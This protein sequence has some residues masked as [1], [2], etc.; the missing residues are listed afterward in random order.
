M[1]IDIDLMFYKS[2]CSFEHSYHKYADGDYNRLYNLLSNYDWSQVY[3][4]TSVGPA[5]DSLNDALHYA[6][7]RGFIRKSKYPSWFSATLSYCIRKKNYF[8][9]RCKNKN[10]D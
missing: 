5:V 8:H 4:N 10:T 3:N 6:I 1:V 2:T 7:S 9:K